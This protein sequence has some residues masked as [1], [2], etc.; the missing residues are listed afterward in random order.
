MK[1][2]KVVFELEVDE[3]GWPPVG[4]ER[5]WA[6]RRADGCC[7]IDNIPWFARAATCGDVVAVREI[8]GAL[9]FQR[10]VSHG[11][12]SLIRIICFKG[13]DPQALRRDLQVLGCDSEYNQHYGMIAVD[14][15]EPAILPG[16][17]AHLREAAARGEIDYEEAILRG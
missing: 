8:D 11:R 7:T 6:I 1:R 17:Q 3:S 13:T 16:V 4:G 10:T 15:P 5:V 14:V 2:V 9:V 12:H